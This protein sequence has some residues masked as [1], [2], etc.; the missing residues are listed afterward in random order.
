[1]LVPAAGEA[2]TAA[3]NAGAMPGGLPGATAHV[4]AA[5]SPGATPGAAPLAHG[6]TAA[7]ASGAA[8]S[9]TGITS[10]LSFDDDDLA[11]GLLPDS[12]PAGPLGLKEARAAFEAKFLEAK[13]KE[14]GGNVSKLA[15]AVGLDRSSLY[16][17]L[18]G[19]GLMAE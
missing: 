12:F 1:V 10:A 17:K 6:G 4:S 13:L 15:E 16:R 8:S 11:D 5:A 14:F 2:A 3:G 7:L 19:Y 18:K 9:A